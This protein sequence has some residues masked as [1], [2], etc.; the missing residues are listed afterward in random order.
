MLPYRD[1]RVVPA[2]SDEGNSPSVSIHDPS[3][4][5]YDYR[6]ESIDVLCEVGGVCGAVS[7]VGTAVSQ[8]FGVPGMP[9]AQPGHCAFL[10]QKR[11]GL[12]VLSNDISGWGESKK[13]E[14]I[15]STWGNSAWMVVLMELCQQG[16]GGRE[17]RGTGGGRGPPPP[18]D[19]RASEYIR[20][21]AG[22]LET[23]DEKRVGLLRRGAEL[24]PC[25]LAVWY[26]WIGYL[27]TVVE[28]SGRAVLDSQT[29]VREIAK[30]SGQDSVIEDDI[31]GNLSSAIL[32]NKLS[33]GTSD[34]KVVSFGREVVAS[35]G[36]ERAANVVD[37]TGS[38]WWTE[39]ET[40]SLEIDLGT[41][42]RI[43]KIEI[44]WWGISVAGD[45]LFGLFGEEGQ[46]VQNLYRIDA[47]RN[48]APGE[49]NEWSI[50]SAFS[51]VPP[52]RRVKLEMRMGHLDPWGMNK[53]FGIRQV[54]V[55]GEA[56]VDDVPPGGAGN[57]RAVDV[58]KQE[59]CRQF[60]RVFQASS[61]A[62]DRCPLEDPLLCAIEH[63]ERRIDCIV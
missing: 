47:E 52:A 21:A 59:I 29:W 16:R 40:A 50:F 60:C 22:F 19:Y 25:N 6:P 37:G 42:C 10:W 8:A 34:C 44:Q 32:R 18:F 38:E 57:L 30:T 55:F 9:V 56:V 3:G 27:Q 13:H 31:I 14:G 48:P 46:L 49:Y 1:T 51:S 12:W 36:Q 17:E 41:N 61:S 15:Q 58:L 7:K 23:G 62:L 35:S 63:L 33:S 4:K 20:W 43:S 53:Q 39:T 45:Y 24:C 54:N 26:A 11:P 2:A 5:Y 28:T